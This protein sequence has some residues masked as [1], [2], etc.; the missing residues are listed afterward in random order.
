MSAEEIE[1]PMLQVG[2]LYS[3]RQKRDGARLRAYNEIL[4]QI[5]NRIRVTSKLPTHPAYLLYTIPPFIFGL[6]K[7]DLED[8][9]VYLV[10][11][12]RAS[13]FEVKYTYPALIYISWKHHE[14]K[15]LLEESPILQ[16]MLAT[17]KAAAPAPAPAPAS[18]AMKKPARKVKF[19][20]APT[21]AQPRGRS[22]PYEAM[23]PERPRRDIDDYVPPTGFFRAVERPTEGG[24]RAMERPATAPE[25][26]FNAFDGGFKPPARL[27]LDNSRGD[28]ASAA[29]RRFKSLFDF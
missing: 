27:T 3:K 14:K 19:S 15:Y 7:I 11:Q 17:Q 18:S 9:V 12:L 28:E 5:Y 13:G 22:Q 1:I 26:G 21:T 8:C 23:A 25:P 4:E 29:A 20:D 2:D 16:A 6:P 24:S 10:Y